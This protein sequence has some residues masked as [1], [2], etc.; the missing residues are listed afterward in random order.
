MD[1]FIYESNIEV[2]DTLF[3]LLVKMQSIEALLFS[4]RQYNA[5]SDFESIEDLNRICS[6]VILAHDLTKTEIGQIE[7]LNEA[8]RCIPKG[9]RTA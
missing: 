2:D 7:A 6:L 5:M 3:E 4:L 9:V 8:I 1:K